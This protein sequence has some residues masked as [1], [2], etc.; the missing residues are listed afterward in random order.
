[1]SPI[2]PTAFLTK[3]L[4]N[5]PR[6]TEGDPAGPAGLALCGRGGTGAGAAAAQDGRAAR[7]GQIVAGVMKLVTSRGSRPRGASGK[8]R[9]EARAAQRAGAAP[10]RAGPAPLRAGRHVPPPARPRRGAAALGGSGIALPAAPS[11]GRRQ[12]AT[13]PRAAAPLQLRRAGA[14][15]G[16]AA[17][18]AGA[19]G[20]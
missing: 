17:A 20:G 5:V 2:N 10:R 11:R 9:E 19:V 13:A 8:P 15:G 14:H 18:G 6:S 7:R 1:M 16:G 4:H 3:T 12:A